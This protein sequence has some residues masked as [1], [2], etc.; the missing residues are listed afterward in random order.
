[1]SA[2]LLKRSDA[3]CYW[4]HAGPGWEQLAA[5]LSLNQSFVVEPMFHMPYPIAN[6]PVVDEPCALLRNNWFFAP[7][8]E[9]AA[10]AM[11]RSRVTGRVAMDVEVHMESNG[12]NTPNT[13]GDASMDSGDDTNT[14][15]ATDATTNAKADAKLWAH[16]A[17][18]TSQ[19]ATK[20]N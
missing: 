5:T 14:G 17:P 11:L 2:T 12:R 8:D 1:M 10:L 9:Q 20:G 13:C 15:T 3:P 6:A 4:L 16:L 19:Q 18:C 7:S